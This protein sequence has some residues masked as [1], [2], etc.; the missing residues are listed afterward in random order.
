M[1]IPYFMDKMILIFYEFFKIDEAGFG[2]WSK[3]YSLK[4]EEPFFNFKF[5]L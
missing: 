4:Y 2:G 1:H 3:L 5:T